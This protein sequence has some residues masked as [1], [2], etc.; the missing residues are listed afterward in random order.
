MAFL[1]TFPPVVWRL[2]SREV[3]KD[4]FLTITPL[5]LTQPWKAEVTAVQTASA[6]KPRS[7]KLTGKKFKSLFKSSY[8]QTVSYGRKIFS[9]F[10]YKILFEDVVCQNPE[11]HLDAISSMQTVM[12][13]WLF[14]PTVS[15]AEIKSLMSHWQQRTWCLERLYMLHLMQASMAD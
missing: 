3:Q 6:F 8:Y 10:H 14:W 2:Y 13:F 12:L 7:E 9:M 5:S 15:A 1:F 11:V 4:S